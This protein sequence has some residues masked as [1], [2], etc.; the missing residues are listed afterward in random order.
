LSAGTAPD[1]YILTC[2]RRSADGARRAPGLLRAVA[3][4]VTLLS[5]LASSA[6]HAGAC[7]LTRAPDMPV[8]MSGLRPMVHAQINGT[9]ALLVADSGSFFNLM[10]RAGVA[11]AHL[12][13]E[14]ERDL[15]VEGGERAEMAFAETFTLMGLTVHDVPFIVAGN[16]F[17]EQAIGL[18]AQNVLRATDV[19]YD[20][21]NGVIRLVQPREC[22]G[23][24]L[25]YWARA[26]G[27]PYSVVDIELATAVE[28][29]TRGIAYLNGTRIR[30][31]FDTGT[32]MSVLTLEAAKRAGITPSSPGVVAGGVQGG[33]RRGT[34]N[35]WIAPFT[36]FKIG[37]EEPQDARL[38][39][40]D[41]HLADVD[42]L[43]GADFFLS[44]RIY[45]ASSQGKLYFT[46]NG[47]PVF[48][49][50]APHASAAMPASPTA[51]D[52]VRG[53]PPAG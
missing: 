3:G 52:S 46:Y 8:T 35:T 49:L 20:L 44:H 26:A 9:D 17:G 51:G 16:E 1:R 31:L 13:L 19:E 11:A 18:V 45:M 2:V 29:H 30:V 15:Y 39:F 34:Y 32:P 5:L 47:G 27:Q 53:T 10:T 23:T 28:P 14:P 50:T 6:G 25:A 21:A 41:L 48:D 38:R 4:P 42:M 22:K 33:L 24:P 37:D 43:I 12:R 40:G 7:T 36:S